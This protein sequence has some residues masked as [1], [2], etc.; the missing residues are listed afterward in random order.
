MRS[1]DKALAPGPTG[2][3]YIFTSLSVFI[4][5][6]IYGFQCFFTGL[7]F[8]EF[9]SVTALKNCLAEN[10]YNMFCRHQKYPEEKVNG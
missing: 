1:I 6:F 5:S 4:G 10:D 2:E 3:S 8:L 9:N 7:P